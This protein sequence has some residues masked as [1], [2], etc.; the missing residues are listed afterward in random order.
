MNSRQLSQTETYYKQCYKTAKHETKAVRIA[1]LKV[2]LM[3]N[4]T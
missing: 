3:I 2:V 4:S 1:Q